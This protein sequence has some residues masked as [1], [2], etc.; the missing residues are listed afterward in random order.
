[1]KRLA[2]MGNSVQVTGIIALNTPDIT[3]SSEALSRWF[4]CGNCNE[5]FEQVEPLQI[6]ARCPLCGG[7]PHSGKAGQLGESIAQQINAVNVVDDASASAKSSWTMSKLVGVWLGLLFF[8]V[9]GARWKWKRPAVA[10]TDKKPVSGEVISAKDQVFLQKVMPA[11]LDAYV[12]FLTSPA[13]ESRSQFVLDPISSVVRMSRFYGLN[14]V[15][16]S[17]LDTMRVEKHHLIQLPQ[18]TALE[19][20]WVPGERSCVE[21]VF[22]QENGEWRLDWPHYARYGDHPWV[23]FLAGDGPSEGEFRVY[24]RERLAEELKAKE[25]ISLVLY[26]PVAG[27]LGE[28]SGRSPECVIRRDSPDGKKI[29]QALLDRKQ[30]RRP[31][32]A[33]LPNLDPDEVIRLRVRMK[34]NEVGAQ[35]G[36]EIMEVKA[37]HWYSVP[38][39]LEPQVK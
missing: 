21:T 7:D 11:C 24:A 37:C 13:N 8:I 26:A 33:L 31:F 4:H 5:L 19:V 32:G 1:M 23:L 16:N 6:G 10:A 18:G 22:Q 17:N 14:A 20:Q 3:S 38:D 9:L 35:R 12:G 39:A 15:P 30:G 25:T 29:T 34:R 28:L 36:F 27:R 2:R